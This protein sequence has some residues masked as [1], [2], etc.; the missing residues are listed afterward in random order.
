LMK[1]VYGEWSQDVTNLQPTCVEDE[2]ILFYCGV[3]C[4]SCL[5]LF[6][7]HKK[8]TQK[9]DLDELLPMEH[10]KE[11][12]S[13]D[14][15]FFYE[16]IAKQ[17]I[18]LA[19]EIINNGLPVDIEEASRLKIELE[20][21]LEKLY[22]RVKLLPTIQKSF[23][24]LRGSKSRTSLDKE[25]KEFNQKTFKGV[26]HTNSLYKNMFI[27]AQFPKLKSRL[28]TK[29]WTMSALK[30]ALG[31][32]HEVTLNFD[33]NLNKLRNNYL[34]IEAFNKVE[35]ELAES[36]E[37]QERM[38]F[39]SKFDHKLKKVFEGVEFKPFDAQQK[40]YNLNTGFNLKSTKKSMDTGED[41]F[42]RKEL[43]Y[44][45]KVVPEDSEVKEYI[46]LCLEHSTVAII[47][48]N[49]LTSIVEKSRTSETIHANFNVFGTK[50]FRPTSGGAINMLAIP[51]NGNKLSKKVKRVF[52]VP[53][54]D[55]VFLTSDFTALEEV[56]MS[57]ITKDEGKIRSVQGDS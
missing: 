33:K 38:K 20:M 30:A 22:E 48:N 12:R 25:I 45:Q 13:K 10:P 27:D 11:D 7:S 3:D 44:Q 57:C 8:E 54:K 34:Y 36:K 29:N 14:Y 19:I 39:E 35:K 26:G 4:S 16:N 51:N 24:E 5:T 50:T 18:P 53:S 15:M 55:W 37:K 41:S 43:E 23:N 42:D 56:V 46:D 2:E 32:D 9:I 17:V 52:K 40:R 1:S 47:K 6:N 31:A 21:T 49:F 28:K